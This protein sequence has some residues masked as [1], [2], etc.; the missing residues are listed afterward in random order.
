[1]KSDK[2]TLIIDKVAISSKTLVSALITA[3]FDEVSS[4]QLIKDIFTTIDDGSRTT[5]EAASL[6]K[7][8]TGITVISTSISEQQ[9]K[10]ILKLK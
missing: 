9:E 6:I 5:T 7:R 3:G 4:E 8:L 1:M 2:R 10:S